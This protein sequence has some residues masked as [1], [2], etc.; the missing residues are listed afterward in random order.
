MNWLVQCC[1]HCGDKAE[2][3][4]DT[5]RRREMSSIL[6]DLSSINRMSCDD[7]AFNPALLYCVT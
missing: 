3:A 5:E 2:R 4:Q 1:N 7:S 6:E